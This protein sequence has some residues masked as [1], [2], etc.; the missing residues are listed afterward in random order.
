L[1]TNGSKRATTDQHFTATELTQALDAADRLGIDGYMAV[2]NGYS[3]LQP[4]HDHDVRAIAADRGVAYT[5]Y[6]PLAGGALTGKYHRGESPPPDSRLALRPEG[7]DE[8]LT[9]AVHDAIDH[10][11]DEA[12]DHHEV[13][14]GALA[15]GWLMHHPHVAAPVIGPSRTAPHLE[16]AQQAVSIELSPGD[17]DRIRSWFANAEHR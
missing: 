6:S 4:D 3:V 7:T 16:L 17:H 1:P 11:R 12:R 10:L 2:Q 14:C 13:S 15:L 8:L 5:A 9:D